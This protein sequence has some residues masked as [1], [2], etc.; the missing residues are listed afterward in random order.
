MSLAGGD[1]VVAENGVAAPDRVRRV[2]GVVALVDHEVPLRVGGRGAARADDGY[3]DEDGD[4]G[5]RRNQPE[6]LAHLS[7]LPSS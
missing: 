7:C 4:R 1:G 3:P 5:D 6:S 2:D